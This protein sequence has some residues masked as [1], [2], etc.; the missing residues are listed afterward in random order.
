MIPVPESKRLLQ[1]EKTIKRNAEAFIE[2]GLALA[3]IR[4]DRLYKTEFDTFEEYCKER[5][6][7]QRGYCDHLIRAAATVKSLPEKVAT[8]V[9]TEGQAREVAKVPSSK[10]AEVIEIAASKA[11][12][13]DRPMTARDIREAAQPEPEATEIPP[14]P[15]MRPVDDAWKRA[16]GITDADNFHASQLEDIGTDCLEHGTPKQIALFHLKCAIWVRKSRP[17]SAR[18]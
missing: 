16:T 12:S 10:R 8:I 6:G 15:P 17:S 4:Q 1:L 3:E 2:T 14:A 13:E 5:W 11:E 9:V 18:I 7:W